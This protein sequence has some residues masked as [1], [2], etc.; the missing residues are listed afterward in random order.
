MF[1]QKAQSTQNV[2]LFLIAGV[3]VLLLGMR[4]LDLAGYLADTSLLDDDLRQHLLPF[5]AEQ[6]A[7][8]F[9]DGLLSEYSSAYLPVGYKLLIGIGSGY[10][11]P[12]LAGKC[13]GAVLLA[14]S[15]YFLF[16]CGNTI[17]GKTG[18]WIA[19]LLGGL[20][21]FLLLQ[22]YAGL[23]RSFSF[24][25][26]FAFLYCWYKKRVIWSGFLL[27]VQALFYPPVA[28]VCWLAF[29]LGYFLPRITKVKKEW[30]KYIYPKKSS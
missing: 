11:S 14:C 21:P 12:L 24:P 27:I 2:I 15:F 28:L 26:L 4:S 18:G 16:L 1:Q 22:T 3:A 7:E 29:S 20:S 13:L 25:L 10:V 23:Y 19:V 9:Q 17:G 30:K 8:K 6:Y 5:Y